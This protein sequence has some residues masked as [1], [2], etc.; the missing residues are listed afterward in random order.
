MWIPPSN[1]AT[2]AT[3]IWAVSLISVLGR[4]FSSLPRIDGRVKCLCQHGRASRKR[5]S[6]ILAERDRE[7]TRDASINN[8]LGSWRSHAILD[9]EGRFPPKSRGPALS[10]LQ[11][12]EF[13]ESSP[14]LQTLWP[15]KKCDRSNS[16]ENCG[17]LT[18]SPLRY[19]GSL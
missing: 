4:Q 5:R 13:K 7:I 8:F 9:A 3:A 14:C 1:W 6:N 17:M 19:A 15:Q 2:G 11:C 18:E 12:S 10:W 16:G